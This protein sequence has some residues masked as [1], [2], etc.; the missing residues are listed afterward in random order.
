M[1]FL[2]KPFLVYRVLLLQAPVPDQIEQM[3][4]EGNQSVYYTPYLPEKMNNATFNDTVRYEYDVFSY[5][6]TP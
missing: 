6:K 3:I 5:V 4:H 2:K 1:F